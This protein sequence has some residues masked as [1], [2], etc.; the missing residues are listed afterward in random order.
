MLLLTDQS[1][2]CPY[3]LCIPV[4]FNIFIIAFITSCCDLPIY[5][6]ISSLESRDHVL[7][8]S[9][10]QHL[11][12]F[13]AHIR[14]SVNTSWMNQCERKKFDYRGGMVGK[15]QCLG[16]LNCRWVFSVDLNHLS[17]SKKTVAWNILQYTMA[18][19]E[20]CS[21]ESQKSGVLFLESMKFF[22]KLEVWGQSPLLGSMR[23]M[24]P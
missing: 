8:F 6:S 21:L 16:D 7:H 14:Y 3:F 18:R 1:F 11:A 10:S 5:P 13:L 9:V 15:G 12:H 24:S 2:L 4:T 23:F 19:P 17:H 22:L 20:N